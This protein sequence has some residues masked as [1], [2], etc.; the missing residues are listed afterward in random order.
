MA[1]A[2][3][4]QSQNFDFELSKIGALLKK[5]VKITKKCGIDSFSFAEFDSTKKSQDPNKQSVGEIYLPTSG[6][7]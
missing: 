5:T 1:R 2:N 6:H 7:V 4:H 3:F